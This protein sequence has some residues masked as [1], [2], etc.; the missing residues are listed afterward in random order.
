MSAPNGILVVDKPGEWT[1]H[2]VVAR[3]R[4]L[5]GTRKVGHAGT[6]DPMA[7][8]V[9]IL[10]LG[11]ST[12][13]LTY[14]VGADKEYL[15]TV[16]LGASTTT[17]DAEGENLGWA[18]AARVRAITPDRLA[19]AVAHLTGEIDQVPSSVSAIKVDGKRAY[20]KVRVGEQVELKARPV[21]V[22]E[23]E[24]LDTREASVGDA[25]ALDV[26]VRVVCSSG[27]YVRALAR[28]LGVA[29]LTGGHLTAL[30]RT[31]VGPFAVTDAR[32]LEN[33]DVAQTLIAPA[34]AASALFPVLALSAEQ[35][36][37]LGHG[38]RIGVDAP[39]ADTAAAVAPDGRL[40]GLA[41]VR[42]GSARTIVNFPDAGQQE[43]ES[44]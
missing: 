20:A 23:F 3:V 16:R 13:L 32:P 34:D 26:D 12:R 44:R 14:I 9:L 1:S 31:R 22:S 15:A 37:D 4:R 18:P 10:G 30:R 6:L 21:T 5:A 33:L 27:T 17:D 8:G 35:A 7:T 38:K 39:D 29:L 24:V 41:A 19:A 43:Q 28:D 11:P 40:V 25:L 36:T 2:D 42:T